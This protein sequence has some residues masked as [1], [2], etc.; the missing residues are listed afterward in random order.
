M[1]KIQI[2]HGSGGRAT[3]ELI[4]KVFLPALKT[5]QLLEME[6]AG[7]LELEKEKLAMSTDS[8]VV[9]PL[10][11][12]GGDIGKLS[13]SGT[14]ND[15]LVSGAVPLYMSAGFILEEGLE[16]EKLQK[17][18]TSF[19]KAAQDAGIV[20]AAAD[21][22]VVEKGKADGL[23][24]NTAGV[25]RVVR[26]LS[27]LSVRPQDVVI[28][29]GYVGDHGI[30]ISV[31]REEFELDIP[32]K[33]DCAPLTG[34]LIPLFRFTGLRWMRDPTRG[35][36]ATVLVELAEK[37]SLGIRLF[38]EKIP[39]R[40]SVSFICE[41]LGY[42]PLYLANEGKAVIVV[43]KEDADELLSVLREHPLGRDAQVIGEIT[44]EFKGVRL[45]TKIGGERILDMLEDDP[46]PRIC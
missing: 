7:I 31:S 5:P 33:S 41:M 22:K 12:P 2:S 19:S 13:V 24:I 30:A 46:L 40:E 4:E 26:E 34:L 9:R 42:D 29:T 3:S 43:S 14:V 10:F 44:D 11:F 39:V 35:G 8:Y 6:D 36:L 27:A 17:V 16:V 18:L 1:E 37:T 23:Y 38:E 25:G 28:V 32:V 20:L 21:T 15:L 45:K